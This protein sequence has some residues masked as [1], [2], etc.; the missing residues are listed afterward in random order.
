M[1]EL[2]TTFSQGSVIA[3]L[4]GYLILLAVSA[5]G[6]WAIFGTL[7]DGHIE[8]T[9]TQNVPW[10]LWVALYIFFLGL[11]AGSFLLSTLVYVFGIKKLEPAG[12]LAL[13]QAL[14]CLVLG[15]M[16]ILLDL[17]HPARM[18]KIITSMN[19]TS[20]M[21]WMGFFYNIYIVVVL[22]EIY[23]AL[24][25]QL[26]LKAQA[27]GSSAWWYRL[28]AL[29]SKRLDPASLARDKKWL[30][31]L[32][33]LGIPIAIT[34]HGG[35]GSIFAVAKAR[36]NWFGGLFP[37]IFLISALASGGAL[38]ALLTAVFSRLPKEAKRGVVRT[39]MRLTVGILA[40]DLLLMCSEIMVTYYGNI[41]H[42][43]AGWNF[44]MFG[45]S[46]WVFWLIQLA[47][48]AAIPILIVINPK[49]GRS[50][51]W[52][53]LA[54]L[55]VVVGIIG[56]RW[57]LVVPPQLTPTF[58]ALPNAYHHARFA[59]GYVPSVHE[60]LV[61]LGVVAL[62]LWAF[63]LLRKLLPLDEAELAGVENHHV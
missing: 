46:W 9:T 43:V 14:G 7:R 45:P 42:E 12:P 28:L 61:G 34:V 24:R 36:P 30:M 5:V 16:L 54:G 19:P 40:F 27:G 22:V 55:L 63:L 15:G 48:G 47:V 39:I 25:P 3:R 18:Y 31:A 50:A 26:V 44:A 20:V 10:G 51:G 17:G 38:L 1:N 29:G 6:V 62:G 11:S 53:G 52:L 4:L 13:L 59:L 33:I 58:D 57:N 21:A 49:T 37:I 2:K 23:F 32:G 60:F 41:P 8:A 35:V 56:A